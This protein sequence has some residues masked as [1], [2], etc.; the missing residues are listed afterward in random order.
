MPFVV[1]CD[2]L[3]YDTFLWEIFS[4]RSPSISGTL[5]PE[6][7]L[8]QPELSPQPESA[9]CEIIEPKHEQLRCGS[10]ISLIQNYYIFIL[11]KKLFHYLLIKLNYN[12]WNKMKITLF[13]NLWATPEVLTYAQLFHKTPDSPWCLLDS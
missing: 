9:I 11:F 5:C 1:V 6:R 10:E 3:S 8:L 4:P 7:T 13:R 12:R 2:F